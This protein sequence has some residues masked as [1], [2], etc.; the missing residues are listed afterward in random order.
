MLVLRGFSVFLLWCC[1]FGVGVLFHC[2]FQL[3]CRVKL[4]LVLY[5]CLC[6]VASLCRCGVVFCVV[7]LVVVF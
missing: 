2:M 1:V 6:V 5:V 3:L 4:Y 7:V